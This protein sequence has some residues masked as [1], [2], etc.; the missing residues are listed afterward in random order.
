MNK[1]LLITAAAVAVIMTPSCSS[2]ETFEIPEKPG[3]KG[4]VTASIST[5]I[6]LE[7]GTYASHNGGAT[8]VDAALYDLR[9]TIEAWT[10]DPTPKLAF[11]GYK[12]VDKDFTSRSVGIDVSLQAAVYDFVIWA[13]FVQ[14]GTTEATAHDAD[15]YYRTNNG[16]TDAQ[17]IADP[18]IDP[19]LQDIR[20]L[21]PLGGAYDINDDARDAFFKKVEFDLTATSLS[22]SVQLRRPFAKFRLIGIGQSGYLVDISKIQFNYVTPSLPTGFN[23]LLSNGIVDHSTN[24]LNV[25]GLTFTKNAVKENVVVKNVTFSDAYVMAFDY[26]FADTTGDGKLDMDIAAYTSTNI[27]V[28]STRS[29][30]NI[31]IQ[32][33]RLTTVMGNYFL[34]NAHLEVIVWDPFSDEYVVDTDGDMVDAHININHLTTYSTLDAAMEA[35]LPGDSIFIPTGNYPLTQQRSLK[36]GTVLKGNGKSSSIIEAADG[37]RVS[38]TIEDVGI[39]TNPVHSLGDAWSNSDYA[40]VLLFSYGRVNNCLINGFA[41]GVSIED[42]GED[43]KVENTEITNNFIGV[44][45]EKGAQVI[46]DNCVIHLNEACGIALFEDAP[47]ADKKPTFTNCAVSTNWATDVY[48]GWSAEY[49]IDVSGMGLVNKTV[50]VSDRMYARSA[51]VSGNMSQYLGAVTTKRLD[52][53]TLAGYDNLGVQIAGVIWCTRNA[54]NKSAAEWTFEGTVK[55]TPGELYQWDNNTPLALTGDVGGWDASW[56]GN[57]GANSPTATDKWGKNNTV[58]TVEPC[59]EGWRLP[60]K[61]EATDLITNTTAS[62]DTDGGMPFYKLTD[63]ASGRSL[64]LRRSQYRDASGTL[65]NSVAYYWTRDSGD[66][67]DVAVAFN[68]QVLEMPRAAALHIRCVKITYDGGTL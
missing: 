54:L 64:W 35:S 57:V 49:V 67:N 11:R 38:G 29:L 8:N 15:L 41:L 63:N 65:D 5:H 12:I 48:N 42:I 62:A 13:D 56:Q 61:Q 68:E 37:I 16:S 36:A 4:L 3:E 58:E 45:I 1:L 40:G 10:Q 66:T 25:S 21:F 27:Q 31:P 30:T 7:I 28:G 6:P 47:N 33:N 46:F 50:I 19:G 22:K 51:T 26:V 2:E 18:T 60:T 39:T 53:I 9:Y 59:P 43:M 44:N 34:P 14:Q 24:L 52:N 17:I 55:T 20:M 32:R 23:A